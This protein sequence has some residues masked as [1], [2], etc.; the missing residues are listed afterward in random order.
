MIATNIANIYSN[1]HRYKSYSYAT[2]N[3]LLAQK[4][5]VPLFFLVSFIKQL[6]RLTSMGTYLT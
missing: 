4:S 6:S 1:C 2:E 3:M 5:K